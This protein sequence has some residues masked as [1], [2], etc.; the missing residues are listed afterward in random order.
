MKWWKG[1]DQAVLEGDVAEMERELHSK[2]LTV[3]IDKGYDC[4]HYD[5]Y[6]KESPTVFSPQN[7][8]IRLVV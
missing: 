1:L 4:I 8:T 3:Y 6:S 2:G 5:S 7:L